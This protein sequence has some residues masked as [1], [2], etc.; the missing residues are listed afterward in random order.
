MCLRVGRA[1]LQAK[2]LWLEQGLQR[3][4]MNNKKRFFLEIR[5]LGFG[6]IKKQ[7]IANRLAS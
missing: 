5:T 2:G 7:A 1:L 4:N 6:N 3:M